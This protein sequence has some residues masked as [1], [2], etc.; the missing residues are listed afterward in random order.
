MGARLQEYP[1]P[2]R[3]GALHRHRAVE[4]GARDLRQKIGVIGVRLVVLKLHHRMGLAGVDQHHGH[5]KLTQLPSQPMAKRPRFHH[6]PL[7]TKAMLF[8]NF[9]QRL[10][11]GGHLAA[12]QNLPVLVLD[13]KSRLFLQNVKSNIL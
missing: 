3:R 8:Q 4:P 9:K 2:L 5:A 12:R 10:R 6:D 11:I 7:R 1:I 13:A